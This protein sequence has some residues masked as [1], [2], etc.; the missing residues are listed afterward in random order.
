MGEELA[1]RRLDAAR[2]EQAR[3]KVEYERAAGTSQERI[4]RL[5]LRAADLRVAVCSRTVELTRRVPRRKG[6]ST[7]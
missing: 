3:L 6:A 4:A 5:R 1:A 7:A 2:S